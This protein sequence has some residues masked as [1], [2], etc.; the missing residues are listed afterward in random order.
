MISIGEIKGLAALIILIE[1]S[2]WLFVA[3]CIIKKRKRVR[4]K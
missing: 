3:Y 4:F 1:V 2:F